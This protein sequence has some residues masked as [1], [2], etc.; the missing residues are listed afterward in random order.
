MSKRYHFI[1]PLYI[2]LPRKRTKDKRV[3]LTLNWYRN[4]HHNESNEVKRLFAPLYSELWGGQAQKI[5]I[6]YQIHKIGRARFD[7]MNFVSVIDKF[8]CDW[9]VN[10]GHIKDDD[11]SRV[12]LGGATGKNQ[13]KTARCLAVVELL[14]DDGL[15]IIP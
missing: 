6:T 1:F 9:L 3:P 11:F 5:K 14:D 7:T 15:Q 4:A 12:S 8:F 13:C 2:E 10:N